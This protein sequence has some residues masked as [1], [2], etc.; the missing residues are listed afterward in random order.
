MEK[1]K[2]IKDIS[3]KKTFTLRNPSDLYETVKKPTNDLYLEKTHKKIKGM[4]E[5]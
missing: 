3:M 4:M 2:N 1:Q 5:R